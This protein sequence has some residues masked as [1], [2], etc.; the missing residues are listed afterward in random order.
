MLLSA[1]ILH[2]VLE[3]TE[4]TY[5]S[6]VDIHPD[7][8][9]IVEGATKIR[10]ASREGDGLLPVE[11]ARFETIRKILVASQKDI[12]IL[13][14]KIFDRSHN[15]ITIDAKKPESQ[16]RIAEETKSIYIPLAKR[17]GLREMY[18]FLQ[19]MTAQVLEPEKWNTMEIFVNN[20][21]EDMVQNS[22]K[23]HLYLKKQDWS[24]PVVHY[25]TDFVSPFS[26]DSKKEYIEE[27]WYAVQI[28]VREPSHCYSVLHD[29]GA[30]RDENF[31]QV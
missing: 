27:S 25:D 29:V 22:K 28:V 3:D 18:H 4:E 13:F 11:Q 9:N 10:A 23:I 26:I 20:Q 15:M 12:R 1:T 7:I 17:C 24:H 19:G 5:E 30:R 21:H 8:A 6:I 16:I 14:L 2:D 31:L